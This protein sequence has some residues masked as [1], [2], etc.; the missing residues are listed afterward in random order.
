MIVLGFR[1]FV[2][3][4]GMYCVSLDEV[5][6]PT[7]L[8][9]DTLFG[10]GNHLPL[11]QGTRPGTPSITR[12]RSTVGASRLGSVQLLERRLGRLIAC[13]LLELQCP[14]RGSV[15]YESQDSNYKF[16]FC[17]VGRVPFFPD[18]I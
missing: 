8:A 11:C 13:S 6:P 1:D 9:E 14:R 18:P 7:R 16:V 10:R 17:W 15:G 2:F 4:D 3:A 12:H 5:N